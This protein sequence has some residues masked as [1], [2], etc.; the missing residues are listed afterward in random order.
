MEGSSQGRGISALVAL[1]DRQFMVLERNNR[2]VGVDSNLDL[3][4]K[5]VFQIDITGA[6]DVSAIDLDAPGASFVT[7]SKNITP[8]LDLAANTPF[9]GNR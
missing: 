3:P 9:L 8:L 4:N 2:G 1:N 6:T 7:V 5:K